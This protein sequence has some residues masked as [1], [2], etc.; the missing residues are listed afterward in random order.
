MDD[1]TGK[2]G[3]KAAGDPYGHGNL[4][5]SEDQRL[6][7]TGD[8]AAQHHGGDEADVQVQVQ[9]PGFDDFHH[10]TGDGT[11][12]GTFHHHGGQNSGTGHTGKQEGQE[13]SHQTAQGSVRPTADQTAQQDGNVHGQENCAGVGNHMKCLRQNNAHGHTHGGQD[14]FLDIGHGLHGRAP[15]LCFQYTI[16]YPRSLRKPP[17]GFFLRKQQEKSGADGAVSPRGAYSVRRVLL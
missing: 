6:D 4:A 8:H 14:N 2:T 13:G 3:D 7:D 16:P 5:G 9:M 15:F 10:Q 1:D 11:V 12:A 17:R